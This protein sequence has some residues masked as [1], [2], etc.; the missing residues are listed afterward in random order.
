MITCCQLGSQQNATQAAF[1]AGRLCSVDPFSWFLHSAMGSLSLINPVLLKGSAIF[2]SHLRIT[3]SCPC[4]QAVLQTISI[5][6][7]TRCFSAKW[8]VLQAISVV[9]ALKCVQHLLWGRGI[10]VKCYRCD[11]KTESMLGLQTSWSWRWNCCLRWQN[12]FSEQ[13]EFLRI[14]GK[15]QKNRNSPASVIQLYPTCP[16]F[17][18]LMCVLISAFWPDSLYVIHLCFERLPY[19][20]H[21]ICELKTWQIFV[22]WSGRQFCCFASKVKAVDLFWF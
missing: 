11:G 1:T 9:G 18:F 7:V 20:L 3:H 21:F 10:K 13:E 2:F 8:L 15:G 6:K 4:G 14:K 16:A 19:K 12:L 22:T 5:G 17:F